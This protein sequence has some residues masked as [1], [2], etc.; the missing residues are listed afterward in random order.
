[1]P[2]KPV[3]GEYPSDRLFLFRTG[4]G[5][6]LIPAGARVKSGTVGDIRYAIKCKLMVYILCSNLYIDAH[7]F[8]WFNYKIG[9]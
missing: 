6:E 5:R 9:A 1:M 4:Q 3:F 8:K 2:V 7:A